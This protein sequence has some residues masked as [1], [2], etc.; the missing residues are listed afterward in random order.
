MNISE[1]MFLKHYLTAKSQIASKNKQ[2]NQKPKQT[3]KKIDYYLVLTTVHIFKCLHLETKYTYM[4]SPDTA[5]QSYLNSFPHF[6][7]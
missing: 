1:K 3:N 7:K 6:S 2:T 4:L 5:S